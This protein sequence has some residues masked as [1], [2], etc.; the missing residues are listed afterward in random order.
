M[1]WETSWPEAP[2]F[3]IGVAP[4]EPGMPDSVSTPTQR[5]ATAVATKA[6]HS[7][8][9]ETCT[10]TPPQVGSSS[11]ASARRPDVAT[12][13]TVPSKPSSATTRLLPPP[14]TSTGSPASSARR[15]ASTTASSVVARPPARAA[16]PQPRGAPPSRNVVWSPSRGPEASATQD[17]H[18]VAEDRL[19]AAGDAQGD[20]A[21]VAPGALDLHLGAGLGHDHRLGELRAELGDPAG[22][23]Q[24]LVDVA[25]G[26][27]EGEHAVRDHVGEADAAGD[28]GVLVDRV[29]VA[30]GPGIGDEGGTRDGVRRC[31]EVGHHAPALWSRVASAVQTSEPSPSVIAL[32]VAMMSVP[33]I[34]RRPLTVRVAVRRS[35]T[36][37]GRSWTNFC[38][39]CTT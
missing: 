4:T 19:T 33:A 16:P 25:R 30:A 38:W 34:W 12:S 37:I 8:P 1:V 22:L 17:R 11:S 36:T 24:L 21:V 3:W 10:T 32:D 2:T 6:S 28:V 26:Q 39:P 13:T 9:A 35:P 15:R 31:R 18:R 7:S 5:R 20:R 29:R 23:A 27:G 14:S